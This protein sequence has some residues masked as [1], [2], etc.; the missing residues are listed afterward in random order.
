MS[1]ASESTFH[2]IV[3]AAHAAKMSYYSEHF[4]WP[5]RFML[6]REIEPILREEFRRYLER[7]APDVLEELDA[8]PDRDL[9]LWG[10]PVE[11]TD[12]LKALEVEAV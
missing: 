9:Q 10:L 3:D 8:D 5:E 12:D 1:S 7:T 6:A 4:A 11:F 2:A